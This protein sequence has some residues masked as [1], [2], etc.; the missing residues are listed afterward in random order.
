[1]WPEWLKEGLTEITPIPG[2]ME[3]D[4]LFRMRPKIDSG[5]AKRGLCALNCAC[6]VRFSCN[7]NN[8]LSFGLVPFPLGSCAVG[9]RRDNLEDRPETSQCLQPDRCRSRFPMRP[10]QSSPYWQRALSRAQARR[11]R[12]LSLLSS[13]GKRRRRASCTH[14]VPAQARGTAGAL[15]LLL[16]QI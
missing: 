1:M 10:P 15:S 3:L 2:W 11:W 7:R 12:W 13:G 5:S 14:R 6:S 16:T 8:V 9:G 4:Y